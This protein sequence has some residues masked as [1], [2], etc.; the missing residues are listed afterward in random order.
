M[1]DLSKWRQ[2]QRHPL[3]AIFGDMAEAEFAELCNDMTEHGFDE[4]CRVVMYEGKV[5]DGW[6][7]QR[8]A[9]ITH[10]QPHYEEYRG[11]DPLAFVRRRNL[12]RRQYD[13]SQRALIAGRIAT[14]KRGG[15]HA[16]Q[17]RSANLHIAQAAQDMGVSRRSAADGKKVVEHGTPELQDAVMKGDISVSDAAKVASEEPAVQNKAVR[18]VR[19]GKA[20]TARAAVA[21]VLLVPA[22][23]R[24][25]KSKPITDTRCK[26][27]LEA[28]EAALAEEDAD[29][30]LKYALE[31]CKDARDLAA[32]LLNHPTIDEV[33]DYCVER[34]KKVNPEQWFAHYEANGWLVGKNRMRDWRAA[35]RT[36]EHSGF[37]NNGKHDGENAAQRKLRELR[38]AREAKK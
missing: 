37:S 16:E 36:W 29:A 15:D 5:L 26:N 22:D 34:G 23:P 19:R 3:S 21:P 7:R 17:K 28:A 20:K 2:L 9:V 4:K 27:L 11:D 8:A 38:E 12:L 18:N 31:V 33:R 14:Y 13:V 10:K 1:I 6:H 25:R 32:D 24:T 30:A 35:V